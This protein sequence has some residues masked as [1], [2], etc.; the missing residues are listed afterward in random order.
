MNV[1]LADVRGHDRVR[2]V[3]A[4][5]LADGRVPPALLL[6]GP[7]GVGKHTL[8]LTVARGLVCEDADPAARPC[9]VCRS[10][11]RAVRG[12]H[13]D[14][15]TVAAVTAVIKIEQVRDLVREISAPPF[16]ARARAFVVDEAHTFTEQAANAL[17]K[18]L[19][20]PPPTSHVLLV[21]SAPQSLLPTIRSRCQVLRLGH[22]PLALVEEQLVAGGMDAA[23]AHLRAALSAGSIGAA[24]A[25]QSDG[26]RAE[27]ETLLALL[28]S[29]R[30]LD[31]FA[32][33]QM[34]EQLEQLEDLP[35]ALLTLRSLLR[36]LAAL[37]S[38]LGPESVLNADVAERLVPLAST[39]LAERAAELA[40]AV[41]EVREGF[42]VN[43]VKL[44]AMDV[45]VDRVAAASVA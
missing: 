22:L 43:A 30:T 39:P 12:A 23:E 13:P 15:H 27:R 35:R 11:T 31:G 19:E 45:L 24:L 40:E 44:L 26:Y 8:A 28:T 18:S 6:T 5:L 33:L 7:R 2:R 20:E 37:R 17:L 34:A 41:W 14:V 21:S 16:E 3:L 38:G 29:A 10:C 32:R 9:D 25:F 1:S 42:R 36:D 4:R